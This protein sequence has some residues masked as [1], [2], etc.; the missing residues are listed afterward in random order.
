MLKNILFYIVFLWLEL[1]AFKILFEK[2]FRKRIQKRK[3]KKDPSPAVPLAYFF[4]R[5]RPKLGQYAAWTAST[6]APL[7]RHNSLSRPNARVSLSLARSVCGLDSRHPSSPHTPQLPLPAQRA[8]PSLLRWLTTGPHQ[9]LP[10][11]AQARVTVSLPVFPFFFLPTGWE[12]PSPKA[13]HPISPG[14]SRVK[15]KTAPYKASPPKPQF[16][17]ASAPQKPSLSRLL[18]RSGISPTSASAAARNHAPVNLLRS[19]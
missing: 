18:S 19:K 3:K 16:P 13:R 7:T 10:P 4:P 2:G 6:P 17:F 8:P 15:I 5:S 9:L 12:S 1:F 11:T 14:F